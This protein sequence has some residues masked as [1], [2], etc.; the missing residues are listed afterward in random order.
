MV[1][2]KRLPLSILNTLS[3]SDM[4]RECFHYVDMSEKKGLML[5]SEMNDPHPSEI[6][7]WIRPFS[8][9]G[10]KVI[11]VNSVISS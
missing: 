9:I 1:G 2:T 5:D 8:V 10:V 7:P 6:T 11:G 4:N 3:L